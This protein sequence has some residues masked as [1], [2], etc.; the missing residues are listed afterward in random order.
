MVGSHPVPIPHLWLLLK[1]PALLLAPQVEA[2]WLGFGEPAV[3]VA[4]G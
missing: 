4:G 1:V 2:V 3:L